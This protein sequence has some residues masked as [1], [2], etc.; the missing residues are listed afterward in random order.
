MPVTNSILRYPGGKSQLSNYV[1]YLIK[2]N[3]TSKIYIEP[4][5]GGFGIALNLLFSNQV[6]K[7]VMND[8]DPSI[9]AVWNAVLNDTSHIVDFIDNVN[10]TIDEWNRQKEIYQATKS[11]P[12]SIKN[13]CATL[14]LNRTNVSG[15]IK[16]G[17]IGGKSQNGKYRLDCRFNKKDL[18]KKILRIAEQKDRIILNNLDAKE[19][20]QT[21][22]PQ[23]SPESTFIFFDPPYYNQG[24]NLYMSFP[25]KDEH[26]YLAKSIV[27]MSNYKW[28][29]T[30]DAEDEIFR[31]YN[32]YVKSF[33]YSLRYSAN[34]KKIAEEYLF[35]SN[36]TKIDSFDKVKLIKV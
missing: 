33:K 22:I 29:T 27:S 17:P 25:N 14:F 1:S 23:Y 4:F 3:G 12:F 20:I 16:G 5:A 13:A 2:L 11:D 28:I 9:F 34:Q 36:V 24:K 19:F 31:L 15:I 10:V 8:Y 21:K 18:R 26:K 30:Y 35:A 6:E 7:V 32:P